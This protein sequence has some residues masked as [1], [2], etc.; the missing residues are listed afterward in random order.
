MRVAVA[1]ELVRP[2]LAE[3]GTTPA[4]RF[5]VSHLFVPEAGEG[6]QAYVVK[7]ASHHARVDTHFHLGAQFQVFLDGGGTFQRHDITPVSVHFTDAYSTYGPIIAGDDGLTFAVLRERFDPGANY[8]PG[9]RDKLTGKQGRNLEIGLGD[10]SDEARSVLVAD[11]DGLRVELH[12]I[13]AGAQ[14]D[15]RGQDHR[16]SSYC[17][18]LEGTARVEGEHRT[19]GPWSCV[20]TTGDDPSLPLR[21]GEHGCRLLLLSFPA[22]TDQPAG[23]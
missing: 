8:M 20:Y 16:T 2:E 17:M 15:V 9:S 21:A 1:D 4:G 11:P 6:P 23:S 10:V 7:S 5:K 12:H 14:H 13:E 3:D 22:A 18:I 19:L